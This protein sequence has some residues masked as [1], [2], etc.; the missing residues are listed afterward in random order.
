VDA[1]LAEHMKGALKDL[2]IEKNA[3]ITE[4]QRQLLFKGQ[5]LSTQEASHATVAGGCHVT[6]I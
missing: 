2:T 4:L 3:E 5:E 6:Y 1:S